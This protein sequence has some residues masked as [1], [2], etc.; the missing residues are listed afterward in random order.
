MMG[1]SYQGETKKLCFT[2]WN[3]KRLEA[4]GQPKVVTIMEEQYS[5]LLIMVW[6]GI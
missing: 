6:T 3:E 4:V 2:P 5:T 1:H